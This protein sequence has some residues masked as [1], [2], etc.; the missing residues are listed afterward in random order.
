MGSSS[1]TQ[2]P[3][4][5]TSGTSFGSK[6]NIQTFASDPQ[7][8]NVFS[9]ADS[10]SFTQAGTNNVENEVSQDHT[11]IYS[12]ND[13]NIVLDEL[14]M[15][16]DDTN[17]SQKEDNE[18]PDGSD[19]TKDTTTE[20]DIPATEEFYLRENNLSNKGTT[21][22][23]I[24]IN[25]QYYREKDIEFFSMETGYNKNYLDYSRYQMPMNGF[26]PTMTL[27]VRT[28]DTD[29]LKKNLV[30]Q[31]DR[32]AV[33]FSA[34]HKMLKSMRCDFRITSVVTNKMDQNFPNR[35]TTQIIHGELYIPDLRNETIR[36]NF[37]G[38]S[39]DAM[40]DV[41]KRLR[42]S[43]F[44]C[45]PEDTNDV[46]VWCNCKTP[47]Q[48]IKELTVHSWKNADSFFESWIDPRYGLSF[49]NVN[50]MLGE[51]GYDEPLD[52]TFFI[53]TFYNNRAIDGKLTEKS[54]E[55]KVQ[56]DAPQAK[57]F[58]NIPDDSDSASTFHVNS[59]RLNNT[60]QEIQDF[61]GLNCKQ[62]F[63]SVNPGLDANSKYS[64]DFSL[65][66]NRTKFDPTRTGAE[67]NFYV[68]LGPGKN[69]TYESADSAMGV[70]ETQASNV[71]APEKVVNQQSDGD[72]ETI[73]STNGNMMSSGNTHKFYEVAYEHNMRNLLQLQKQIV[74]VEL[75][76]PN[77]AIL[78]GEKI[79]MMLID[80]NRA[81][82]AIRA[83][84]SRTSLDAYLFEAVCG[85][86]IIDGIEWVYDPS[87]GGDTGT[88]WRTKVKLTRRE[89][90]IPGKDNRLNA[91][92]ISDNS[93][94]LVDVGNGQTVKKAYADA[95][96]DNNTIISAASNIEPTTG[97][98]YTAEGAQTVSSDEFNADQADQYVT[99]ED[100]VS[101]SN[102]PLTGLKSYMKDIY[103]AI[104]SQSDNKIKL[105][106]ARRWAVDQYGNKV[107][108]NAFVKK[109]GYY[110]CMNAIGE[111]MYFKTNNSK[112]LYG[113]AID[114][115]NS[116]IDF[117]ELLTNVIMKSGQI[118]R[119]LY[120]NGVSVYIEQAIDDTGAATKH[121]H[122]GTDT[123]KQ[124]EFWA[125]VKAVLGTDMIPGTRISF[126][127][128]MRN[129]NIA[130]TEITQQDVDET[131]NG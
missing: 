111:T 97:T 51:E 100:K 32:C 12:T 2:P 28:N 75:N 23:L 114:I 53:N 94:V 88:Y 33:Y 40:M 108:G 131:I 83:G 87:E 117:N 24:R 103:R 47:E 79:P 120:D 49:I 125:S 63:E 69:T 18:L 74:E 66:L 126:S 91:S 39:R 38:S 102:I 45:D 26:V 106:S 118:L 58:T 60:A 27:I 129:N 95:V 7:A 98:I 20:I 71:V 46:M 110:K 72:A 56:T 50:K 25:D 123:I 59:W 36:Y 17:K 30:K 80:V 128:Y 37:N 78:R 9:S 8:E 122:I 86:Y 54:A 65:C 62:Q 41:A 81:E 104:A 130:S 21:Y 116:G 113:E 127:N 11:R 70:S 96:A 3:Y 90:P 34:N 115:I 19:L 29:S 22:P 43:Y 5:D 57:I 44:F 119:L 16:I 76:G 4:A 112:H 48:F 55:E 52:A 31:G 15:L 61:I 13:A 35:Y 85:W 107:D 14:S 105:V 124:K 101:T 93:L 10:N 92:D 77:L 109:N 99:E 121:Y 89:W 84:A 6:S 1:S 82:S 68:L 42:L 64:V 73:L 67:N